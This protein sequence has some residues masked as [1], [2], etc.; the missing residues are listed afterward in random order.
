[1]PCNPATIRESDKSR[2]DNHLGRGPSAEDSPSDRAAG[3]LPRSGAWSGGRLASARP[4]L[5]SWSRGFLGAVGGEASCG[6][7]AWAAADTSASSALCRAKLPRSGGEQKRLPGPLEKPTLW[8]WEAV[9]RPPGE[10]EP[11]RRSTRGDGR[12]RSRGLRIGSKRPLPNGPHPTRS[13]SYGILD[14]SA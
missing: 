5:D 2:H 14:C 7:A 13:S 8:K 11:K 6:H 4:P 10:G 12:A 9:P 3:E 1:M